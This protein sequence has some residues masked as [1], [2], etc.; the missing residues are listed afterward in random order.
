MSK[1]HPIFGVDLS[2]WNKG[3][4]IRQAKKQGIQWGVF[5]ATEG[6]Y[7]DGSRYRDDAYRGFMRAAATWRL[8]VRGAYH[9]LVATN[10]EKQAIHFLKTVGSVK[11]KLLMVDF[12]AY[13]SYPSLTPGNWHLDRFIHEVK[14]RTN[15]HKVIVYSGK[16]FWEGGDSSG[17]FRQYGAEKAWDAYYPLGDRVDGYRDLYR[18]CWR[19]GWGVRWGNVEPIAWQYTPA[20]HVAGR[21]VDCNA[22][23]GSMDDLKALTR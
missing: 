12:E 23:R 7:R 8:P 17:A 11:N 2:H 4:S 5:K 19:D 6:P 15:D 14:R 1:E 20:G 21:N 13:G 3:F 22:F 16:G 18:R 9:F 10:P